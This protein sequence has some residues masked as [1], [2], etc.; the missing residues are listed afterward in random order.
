MKFQKDFNIKH[1]ESVDM[2]DKEWKRWDTHVPVALSSPKAS[3][4]PMRALIA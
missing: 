3:Q 4:S 2:E 1:E